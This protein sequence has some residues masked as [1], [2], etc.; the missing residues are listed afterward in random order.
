MRRIEN[1]SRIS[2]STPIARCD[3]T[4]TT[5]KTT[6]AA[7]EIADKI[8]RN[9]DRIN[10]E[11]CMT[12]AEIAQNVIDRETAARDATI[13]DLKAK[14]AQL[15]A[16]LAESR[17]ALEALVDA[18][19]VEFPGGMKDIGGRTGPALIRAVNTLADESARKEGA[20]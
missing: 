7:K 10:P 6:D 5:P 12:F 19:N 8:Q 13:T 3:N 18:V 15:C 1:A 2:L 14:V 4:M 11:W 9:L 20:T 16:Q 17:D